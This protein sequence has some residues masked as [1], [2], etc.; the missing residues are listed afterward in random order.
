[1]AIGILLAAGMGTR[2]RPLT[3]YIPKPLVRVNGKPMIETVIEGLQNCGV[4]KIYIVVGYLEEKF[5]S[6]SEK[7]EGIEFIYNPNYETENNISSIYAARDV[8]GIDDCF[9]CEADIVVSDQNVLQKSHEYSCYYG[10]MIHGHSEDWVFDTDEKGRISRVGKI[11]D[12]CYNMVGIAYLK[13]E[14]ATVL[15]YCVDSTYKNG[16]YKELFWDDVVNENLDKLNLYVY[17]VIEDQIV[18]IDTISEL[19]EYEQ[20]IV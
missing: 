17:P 11:G 13:K 5:Q 2:M 9:V 20:G 8:L 6:L 16:N 4:K 10:K 14:D 18:E 7:Y 19:T 3:E 1:M 12:D 15:K